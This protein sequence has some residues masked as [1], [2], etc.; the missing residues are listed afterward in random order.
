VTNDNGISPFEMPYFMVAKDGDELRS[1]AQVLIQG[2]AEGANRKTPPRSAELAL[3]DFL[4]AQEEL[5]G[6]EDR[7]DMK[8][9][10]EAVLSAIALGIEMAGTA[11]AD[12]IMAERGENG[13]NKRHEFNRKRK[14]EIRAW[15]LS[16]R[17]FTNIEEAA[18]KIAAQAK[19]SVTTADTW[20]KEWDREIREGRSSSEES[21]ES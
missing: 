20:R 5:C 12:A 2:L 21:P 17:P 3:T 14:K 18:E 6:F 16:K 13:R 15:Y 11:A 8:L 9:L 1:R 10:S 4:V 19:V 7:D